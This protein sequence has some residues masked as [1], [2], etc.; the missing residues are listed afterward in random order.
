MAKQPRQANGREPIEGVK[1]L[2]G[3][4]Y[5][6]AKQIL[7][8]SNNL[9][10]GELGEIKPWL[11]STGHDKDTLM[12]LALSGGGIRSA[13]FSLGVLQALA[14]Y[15]VLKKM[16]YLSTVSGGGYIGSS[17][18][19]WL[20]KEPTV[21][22]SKNNFPFGSDREPDSH[23]DTPQQRRLRHLSQH[24][25]YLTPGK[26]ITLLS[27]I[28]IV[29]CAMLANLAVWVPVLIFIML[30]LVWVSTLGGDEAL[31][32]RLLLL[33]A[34][35]LAAAFAAF[36]LF[37]S[38]RTA[39]KRAGSSGRRYRL[40]RLFQRLAGLA[41][42]LIAALVVIGSVPFVENLLDADE[43]G[44]GA[45]L[46]GLGS[47]AWSFFKSG[48]KDDGKIKILLSVIAPVGAAF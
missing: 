28:A 39:G 24:G 30:V 44:P 13:T 7:D 43:A 1:P 16:D 14:K 29:L 36:C 5:V 9:V 11:D 42:A 45:V 32:F 46:V 27:G 15:D 34:A 40:R 3:A 19:W 26:G 18:S 47:A 2:A 37:Y 48:Q 23:G 41:L 33:L 12:G 21:G 6:T 20:C 38:L 35:V 8:R 4:Q 31:I 22:L 25:K 17:L 10:T